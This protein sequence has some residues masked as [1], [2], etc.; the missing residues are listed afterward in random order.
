MKSL[1]LLATILTGA[2]A[3]NASAGTLSYVPIPASGSDTHAGLDAGHP[4]T[5]AS[6]GAK[7]GPGTIGG[8]AFAPLTG[9]GN[10]W[11]AKGV[12]LS[13]ATGT[14]ANG[15]G[16]ADSIQADGAM[17]QV[18]AGMILNEGAA[19]NS[20]QYVA[21]DTAGM[22]AGKSYDMRVYVANASGQNRE[23]SL[24]FVGDEAAAAGT[25]FF[26]EDDA[27]TSP[28]GFAQPNQAYYINYRFK[29]DG[30]NTPGVTI[31]QRYGSV[32]F[33]LYALTNQEAA[34]NQ[35][36][37]AFAPAPIAAGAA[38]VIRPGR[39]DLIS[40]GTDERIGV[41]SDV[42]Y[43]SESLRS[44]GVWVTVGN[45]GRCWRPN[46]VEADWSPYTR[47]RW[48][49]S[50]DD[51]WTW[52]SEEDWGWATY[53]YGRWFREQDSGWNW[54]PGR[55]WAP[56][57]VSWRY[58]RSYVGWAP[59]PPEALALAGVGIGRW[60]DSRWGIGP[61][62]YNFVNVQDFGSPSMAGVILPRGGNLGLVQDTANITNIVNNQRTIYSGGPNV[63]AV[64]GILSRNG[65]QPIQTVRIDRQAGGNPVTPDGKFSQLK[66]GVLALAAPNVSPRN[67]KLKLP[68]T[69]AASIKSPKIDRGWAG[70]TDPN[71]ASTLK[72]K[73]AG[74]VPGKSARNAPAVMPG[75][76]PVKP[77][78]SARSGKNARTNGTPVAGNVLRPGKPVPSAGVAAEPGTAMKPGGKNRGTKTPVVPAVN[79]KS[80]ET[81]GAV[82][83]QPGAVS[84]SGGKTRGAKTPVTAKQGVTPD[85]AVVQPAT[86]PKTGSA[87]KKPGTT[88]RTPVEVRPESISKHR[89]PPASTRRTPSSATP[90]QPAPQAR[91]K[92]RQ[93]QPQAQPQPQPQPQPKIRQPKAP[94][95]QRVQPQ[96]Q[97][98]PR[99]QPKAQPQPKAP[100][101]P[102]PQAAPQ[103]QPAKGK[104]D[105]QKPN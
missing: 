103:P 52:D 48:V 45:Y 70:V 13:A 88:P 1:L 3:P 75:T 85:A 83:V 58:G 64:N 8:V 16:K 93:P 6:L 59:L 19:D 39:R 12:T 76:S 82:A 34:G 24:S 47:G 30:V 68:P 72:T 102:Q 51:G 86:G 28:G 80:P 100:P 40:S 23:V 4:Y 43:E 79:A 57:W 38:Q 78:T 42:F 91:Q 22:T 97:A 105:K 17:A 92:I 10:V 56:S 49:Y 25:D 50:G 67:G 36:E 66:G 20:E 101:A 37:G 87:S 5:T 89:Q 53:H 74:E 32:P 95:Q 61:Q 94:P 99:R 65:K 62:A 21:L 35:P 18:F 63:M 26:N 9:T 31:T 77:G 71:A 29:W 33:C 41:S 73:I 2:W 84:K 60:A 54:V 11:V 27:T 69:G 90:S 104:H 7:G 44:N 96:P 55:V 98:Q 15:V 81:P 46:R 14:L